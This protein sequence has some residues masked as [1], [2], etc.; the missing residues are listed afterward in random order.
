MILLV[1]VWVRLESR[2]TALKTLFLAIEQNLVVEGR[3]TRVEA[4][5]EHKVINFMWHLLFLCCKVHVNVY[6]SETYLG[7]LDRA[8]GC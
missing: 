7:R 5:I 4:T 1:D 8:E 2:C 6:V 3:D